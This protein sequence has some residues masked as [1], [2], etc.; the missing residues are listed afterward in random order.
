MRK[1]LLQWQWRHYPD[2]HADRLNLWLHVATAPVFAAGTIAVLAAPFGPAWLAPAGL[3]AMAAAAAIQAKGHAR[4]QQRPIPF[5]GPADFLAR[6]FAE[7]WITF[8]RYLVSG[9]RTRRTAA[10]STHR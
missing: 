3:L 9:P 1:N 7:N 5:T 2:V 10:E 6:L 8:W 4:E